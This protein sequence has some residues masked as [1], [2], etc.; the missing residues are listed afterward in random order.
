MP[1][2]SLEIESIK[3]ESIV[4]A[5]TLSTSENPITLSSHVV[6]LHT[7]IPRPDCIAS[8]HSIDKR[9]VL[10]PLR[11]CASPRHASIQSTV[12]I[13]QHSRRCAP[14]AA[15]CSG[16]SFG[17]SCCPRHLPVPVVAIS[18]PCPSARPKDQAD[19]RPAPISLL[20]SCSTIAGCLRVRSWRLEPP[21][22]VLEA[23]SALAMFRLSQRWLGGG[24][25]DGTP[26][27]DLLIGCRDWKSLVALFFPDMARGSLLED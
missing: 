5:I 25:M 18:S 12:V 7:C 15:I 4:F 10:A 11:P 16:S 21:V 8:G 3:A 20:S 14:S 23:Q 6:L 17:G 22:W 24:R 2:Q 19:D 26:R 27:D 1:M 13:N 9:S